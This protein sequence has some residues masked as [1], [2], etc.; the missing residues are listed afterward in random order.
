MTIGRHDK[1]KKKRNAPRGIAVSSTGCLFHGGKFE[2]DW[3]LCI[4]II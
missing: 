3:V 2:Q 1:L 4:F